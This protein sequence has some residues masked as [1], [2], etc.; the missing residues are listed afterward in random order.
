MSNSEGVKHNAKKLGAITAN[1]PMEKKKIHIV[2]YEFL[3]HK[4]NQAPSIL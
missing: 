3:H 1:G 4:C 2:F